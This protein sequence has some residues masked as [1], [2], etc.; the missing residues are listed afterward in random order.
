MELLCP[1]HDRVWSSRADVAP[2]QAVDF[3]LARSFVL[4]H[5]T[6]SELCHPTPVSSVKVWACS[7][8]SPHVQPSRGAVDT[9]LPSLMHDTRMQS[10]D[11]PFLHH[12]ATPAL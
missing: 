12:V 3:G 7:S 8:A 4:C 10:A 11:C 1:S 2:A 9:R 6:I 5:L